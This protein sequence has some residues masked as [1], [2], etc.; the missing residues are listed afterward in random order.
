MGPIVKSYSRACVTITSSGVCFVSKQLAR[1][2]F[3]RQVLSVLLVQRWR[4]SSGNVRLS[5]L[6]ISSC[7]YF[8]EEKWW[9][10]VS[11]ILALLRTLESLA[12][13]QMKYAADGR[14]SSAWIFCLL[15][16][17]LLVEIASCIDDFFVGGT[18]CS[19]VGHV[20]RSRRTALEQRILIYITLAYSGP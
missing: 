1:T 5:N 17:L 11:Q 19:A 20:S 4:G 16:D 15:S 18:T 7:P 9:E 12:L 3:R 14:P 8:D 2:S 6:L 10:G 13:C